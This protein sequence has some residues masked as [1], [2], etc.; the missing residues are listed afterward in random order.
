MKKCR[1][2]AFVLVLFAFILC[3]N[4]TNAAWLSGRDYDAATQVQFRYGGVYTAK[5]YISLFRMDG[6]PAFCIQDAVATS[7]D[8]SYADSTTVEDY[9]NATIN[10]MYVSDFSEMASILGATGG[11]NQSWNTYNSMSQNCRRLINGAYMYF[12]AH[13]GQSDADQAATQTFIWAVTNGN[14][15]DYQ[16]SKA[17]AWNGYKNRGP[18]GYSIEDGYN[19]M[20]IFGGN[21]GTI[22]N[23]YNNIKNYAIG[24]NT[25]TQP[26]FNELSRYNAVT[27]KS[28][29]SLYFNDNSG[30]LS[31]GEWTARVEGNSQAHAQVEG[32]SL[33]VWVDDGF[34][35]EWTGNIVLERF[36][37]VPN[38]HGY[39]RIWDNNN[40]DQAIWQG[41]FKSKAYY[42][43]RTESGY[44]KI[45]KKDKDNGLNPLGDATL[46]GAVYE[47]YYSN[48]T[49]ADRLTIHNN[50]AT[51][52]RLPNGTYTLKEVT[53]PTGYN[54]SDEVYTITINTSD[55]YPVREVTDSVKRGTVAV[56]K[57]LG[58][59]D[60]DPEI[61]LKGAQ[62]RLTLKKDASQ[63]YLTNIAGDDGICQVDNVPYGTYI[64]HEEIVPD[65]AYIVEDF[66]ATISE[67]GQKVTFTKV[68]APK[69]MKI[70]LD[71]EIMVHEGEATD[72]VLEGAIFTVYLDEAATQPYIDKNGNVVTI[73]PT[74]VNG[75]AESDY[76]RTGTYYL[77]E[78][79]FPVGIDPDA[80]IPG[81]DVT[82]REKVYTASYDNKVQGADP[83]TVTYKIINEPKRHDI[84]IYK[85]VGETSNTSQFPLD[86]CEFTATLKS[87]IGTDHVFSRKCTAET[88]RDTG[89]CIIEDLPY[90]EY[91]VEE[92]KVSPITLKCDNFTIFVEKDRKERAVAYQPKD[93]TFETTI[94]DQNPQTEWVDV[95]GK[96]VDI[97]KVM[98]IKI[99]KID[100]NWESTDPVDY[101]Q[102]D[103]TLKGAIYRITRYDPETDD[104]TEP[105]Y[106]I[107]VDHQD[108][109]GYWCAESKELLVGKYKVKE[110]VKS[111]VNGH[112]YSYAEGYLVDPN[113]Y[114]FEVKP[115]EQQV[116]LSNHVDV[117]KEEV[118]RG[119]VYILKE[120]EDR[121][122]VES[123]NDSEKNPAAGA[124]MRL[125]LD[126]NPNTYYEVTLDDRGYGEFIETNDETHKSTAAHDSKKYY[127]YTI[128]YG[129]YTITETQEG[130]NTIRTNFYTQDEPVTIGEQDRAEYRIEMDN[131][132][133]VW[134]QIIKKDK[135]NNQVVNIPNGKYKIWDCKAEGF[136][137]MNVYPSS[138]LDEFVSQEDGKLMLPEKL[139]PGEYII[140]E[141]LPP[142]GYFLDKEWRLPE[143]KSDWGDPTKGG[144]KI[145]IDKVVSGL[146]ADAQY[147]GKVQVGEYVLETDI[148]NKALRVNLIV[149]KKGEKL[150]K[151]DVGNTSYKTTDG[152]EVKLTTAVP[153]F[154]YVG[155][156]DVKFELYANKDIIDPLGNI[157]AS[158]DEKVD[159]FT[160]NSEGTG[161][162]R[163]DLYPGEYRLHEV[164]APEGY[165]LADDKIVFL[166]NKN[167]LVESQSTT[168]EVYDKRQRLDIDFEKVFEDLTL[169]TGFE[170]KYAVFGVYV[171]E[172]I[173]NYNGEPVLFADDLVEVITVTEDYST[174]SLQ[175]DLPAGKYYVKELYAGFPYSINTQRI[176]F[177]LKYNGNTEKYTVPS[178][179][180]IPNTPEYSTVLFV[181]IAKS[182]DDE[183]IMNGSQ[184]QS[185]A[186]LDQKIE[187]TI[188]MLKEINVEEL[189][190]MQEAIEK[191]YE[192]NDIKV[193]PGAKYEIWL[194]EKGDKKVSQ[195][196]ENGQ[197]VTA[198]FETNGSG[199]FAIIGIP[200]GEYY[201]K[202]IEAPKGF[203]IAKDPVKFIISDTDVG[204]T[205]Y[206]AIKEEEIIPKL[207]HKTDV[208][209]GDGVPNCLFEITDES[210]KV[211]VKSITDKNG[212]AYFPLSAFKDGEK[213]YF[214]E[215]SVDNDVYYIE[216]GVL[217]ELNTE[218][219][220][221]VAKINPETGLW[222]ADLIEVTNNRPV[223]QVELIK[224]DDEGNRVPNCKFELKSVEDGLF[225]EV[226]VTDENGIYVFKDVPKGKYIYTELEAPEEYEIDTTPHEIYV[227]GEKMVIEFVNTGD[228]PVIALS[229]VALVSVLGITFL[230]IKKNKASKIA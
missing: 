229:V 21:A 204:T 13:T 30:A 143:N 225:Y 138:V 205:M 194:D 219:H 179:I 128:P 167:Y 121:S 102:G 110:V 17:R 132:V 145:K 43:L 69:L 60:Y 198:T 191:F 133:P 122:N 105:V 48:G 112:D 207:L 94:L 148:Y 14:T 168:K 35:G 211:I 199:A 142:Q 29:Q 23:I 71:K 84:E 218:K 52:K 86:Q 176:D 77:K 36:A 171:K 59:T 208:F 113:E 146:P 63:T 181:K 118:I 221:F 158:K 203:E 214:Q 108:E 129:K 210:G 114:K 202:E 2:I 27:V 159:E 140:Y 136:V 3:F 144:K 134:L 119:I 120:D 166:E 98:K 56:Y 192:E 42:A 161:K 186:N 109:D 20:S 209:T 172:N 141:T 222:D 226:G 96:L 190:S 67:Q 197:L 182:S 7:Y 88:T 9:S 87:T 37:N 125:S 22:Q 104:Y 201:L 151:S 32:N 220:E 64:V 165:V 53:A 39:M 73:G 70:A 79:T 173:N 92:T 85:E 44:F 1:I 68:D 19:Y 177:E 123:Q 65:P 126:K 18:I 4:T 152:E 61:A 82:Y 93:G 90:G 28:G 187:K 163:L 224:T 76:M 153:Y 40:G 188:E 115:D 54:L 26:S 200:K 195:K 157:I 130:T 196:D 137:K 228:I 135:D 41:G 124:I 47:A 78:T 117:S 100:A 106:D 150:I 156:A 80:V 97:P 139:N 81:E 38:N 175:E 50:E 103:A 62:F 31:S 183:I 24:F 164:S 213:Y 46:D 230:I 34:A 83:V 51:S 193:V 174:A 216:K 58:E 5:T 116:R 66:E 189:N 95:H 25:S 170:N 162:S 149:E 74:D 55:Y 206:Q 223:T 33:H 111:S 178:K 57:R 15:W 8:R 155:L 154:D 147:P 11:D 45:I 160:T 10:S 212:D 72:A 169:F 99:R 185:S 180:V 127:P 6:E 215:I 184:M 16:I 101:T 89:Y 131:P 12:V 227:E 217:Y 107:T 91:V 75:H 49:V